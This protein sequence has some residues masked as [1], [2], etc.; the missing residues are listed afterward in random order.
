[1]KFSTVITNYK[2]EKYLDEA[3]SSVLN[4]YVLP[5]S[6]IVVND[7]S[8]FRS[9]RCQSAL[10]K[11]VDVYTGKGQANALNAGISL[12][13]GDVVTFLD[14]D[15][16]YPQSYYEVLLNIYQD[17]KADAIYTRPV[18]FKNNDELW[19]LQKSCKVKPLVKLEADL[20][21]L[22]ASP[23]Y[24]WLGVPTSGISIRY[25]SNTLSK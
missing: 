11:Y 18:A 10:I 17:F 2:Y 6:I 7:N 24:W 12:A 4:Q 21:F 23:T 5:E 25:I 13:E 1:M 22:Q 19:R 16:L 15:D 8:C 14:A 20:C 9:T 3:I